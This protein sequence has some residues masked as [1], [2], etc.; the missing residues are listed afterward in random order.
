[1]NSMAGHLQITFLKNIPN[2]FLHETICQFPPK[3][4]VLGYIFKVYWCVLVTLFLP[5]FLYNQ[6]GS[7]VLQELLSKKINLG[8]KCI[9][10]SNKCSCNNDL[11]RNDGIM[12]I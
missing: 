8:C 5:N 3:K 11:F 4:A 9:V 1:M 7:W 6:D 2:F 10:L 12:W